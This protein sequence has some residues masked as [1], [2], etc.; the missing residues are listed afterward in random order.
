MTL[1]KLARPRINR[2]FDSMLDSFFDDFNYRNSTRNLWRPAMNARDL[3]KSYELSFSLPGFEKEEIAISVKNNT[4]TLKA[5]KAEVKEDEGVTY[6]AR[7]IAFGTY[8]RNID[9]PENVN[10]DKITAEYKSGILSLSIPKTKEALPK[11]I[12]VTIK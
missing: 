4:L 12:A 3:E 6:L 8:E 1:V 2:N 5:E 10:S 9:L 7:E 11:E